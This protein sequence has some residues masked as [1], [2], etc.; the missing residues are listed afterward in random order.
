M[1]GKELLLQKLEQN[2]ACTIAIFDSFPFYPIDIQRLLLILEQHP[3]LQVLSL[4]DCQ[5]DIKNTLVIA[6]KIQKNPT[7]LQ[8]NIETFNRDNPELIAAIGEMHKHLENNR[9]KF[10]EFHSPRLK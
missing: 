9:S 4:I 3:T 8:V 5:L 1:L 7:L 10:H 6:K 2:E